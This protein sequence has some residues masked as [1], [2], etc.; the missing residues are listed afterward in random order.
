MDTTVLIFFFLNL[1]HIWWSNPRGFLTSLALGFENFKFGN[2]KST[3]D[4][5]PQKYSVLRIFIGC[6]TRLPIL[7]AMQEN[8]DWQMRWVPH[9]EAFINVETQIQCDK[10]ECRRL[11]D[12]TCLSITTVAAI[13]LSS[14]PAIS[15]H[16]PLEVTTAKQDV[17][18]NIV[19]LKPSRDCL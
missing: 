12:E 13:I 15:M 10:Q 7:E 6:V 17:S 1:R 14:K 2:P 16:P 5:G 3:K 18:C 9:V 4:L 8:C 19:V 11:L